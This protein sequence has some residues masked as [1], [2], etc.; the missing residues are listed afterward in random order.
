MTEVKIEKITYE[1]LRAK[2]PNRFSAIAD[3]LENQSG[4]MQD[5]AERAADLNKTVAK[6]NIEVLRA[7]NGI[8]EAKAAAFITARNTPGSDN[9]KLTEE[10][11][12]SSAET[13]T[14]VKQA[15]Q[16]YYT[17]LEK[18]AEAQEEY[19]KWDD[20]KWNFK[21]KAIDVR[22]MWEQVRTGFHSVRSDWKAPQHDGPSA[23]AK[24]KAKV[25]K[26]VT[27]TE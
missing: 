23:G 12:K 2:M 14:S 25:D 20:L 26:E 8:K 16:V 9:K 15:K 17:A 22:I 10:D 27:D 19:K 24:L 13:S 1:E 21:E 7:E 3:T 5:I 11:A 6:A 18:Q 4:W